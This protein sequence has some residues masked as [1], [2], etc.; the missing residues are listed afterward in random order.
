M[1]TTKTEIENYLV[2]TIDAGLN[3]Q[4]TL[5]ISAMQEYIHTLANRKIVADDTVTTKKYTG[6]NAPT[7]FIDDVVAV[8]ELKVAGDV[9]SVDDYVT[10]PFNLAYK[11][12]IK[13]KTG[14][15]FSRYNEGDIEVKGRAGMYD[16]DAIPEDLRFACTV[17][18]AGIVQSSS[19]DNKNIQSETIGRYTVS[20]KT[21]VQK[22][23]YKNAIEIAKSY[24]RVSI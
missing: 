3:S 9:V 23:D 8:T 17:L 21:D 1:I 14:A 6:N 13:Y 24:R 11:N 19:N 2:T 16:K 7:L 5:W 18:V 10:K 15:N 4:V 22:M 12:Q 20:Y